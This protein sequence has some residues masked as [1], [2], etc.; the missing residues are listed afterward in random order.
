VRSASGGDLSSDEIEFLRKRNPK[1]GGEWIRRQI[2]MLLVPFIG[3]KREGRR[4]RGRETV[5]DEWSYSILPFWRE[6]KKGQH[7]FWKGKGACEAALSS[8]A[9]GRPHDAVAR[10]A[11]E[12]GQRLD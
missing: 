4:Y 8:H 9:E 2:M 10:S 1:K 11:S 12:V 3:R 6:E 5:D 7:S